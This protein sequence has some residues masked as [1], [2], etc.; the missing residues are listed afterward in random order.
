MK[1]HV[2]CAVCSKEAFIQVGNGAEKE[3]GW[4][5]FGKINVNSC[6][7][8]KYFYRFNFD[9]KEFEKEKMPN[10]CYNPNIK[11]KFV[12]YWECQNCSSLSEK[13]RT[14]EMK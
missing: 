9:N 11:P 13:H 3:S 12:E 7:T 2:T 10:K 5:F 4:L 8:T 1:H 14:G 6:Q